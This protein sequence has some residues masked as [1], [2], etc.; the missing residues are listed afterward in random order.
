[1]KVGVRVDL[2]EY[3]SPHPN[4]GIATGGSAGLWQTEISAGIGIGF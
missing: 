1:M 3:I 2:R 4:F